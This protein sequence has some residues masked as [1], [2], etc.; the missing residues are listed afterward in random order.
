MTAMIDQ[1][2]LL[3][4][5]VLAVCQL[6]ADAPVPEWLPVGGLTAVVRTNEELSI[7][8]AE[9]FVPP[10]VKAEP[11]WRCFQV[12]GP[13]DFKLVGILAAILKPLAEAG[14]SIFVI[15]TY[16]TDYILV[17]GAVLERATQ[18][19]EGAGYLVI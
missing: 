6:G 17:K 1:P 10:D 9:R 15:S 3:H 4:P 14:V 2:L 16:N 5:E 8:C 13:L 12:G 7:V 11:G 19:L 18:A